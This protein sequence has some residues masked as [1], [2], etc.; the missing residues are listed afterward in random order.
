MKNMEEKDEFREAYLNLMQERINKVMET[1]HIIHGYMIYRCDH[2]GCVYFMNLEKGLEDP[3]DDKLTG[4][5][6]PVPFIISCIACGSDCKHILWGATSMTYGENYRSYNE[7]IN[8]QDKIIFRNLFW[9]DPESD[10]GV[11]VVF[12]PDF[13]QSCLVEKDT[14]KTEVNHHIVIL[15]QTVV[16]PELVNIESFVQV[17]SF[18]EQMKDIASMN[19]PEPFDEENMNREQRRHGIY[20]K[21]GY[22]RPRKNKKLYEY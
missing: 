16:L 6:K 17:K 12:E 13:F 18:E 20:G 9:N 15:P 5:H 1:D 10:C 4:K 2:C 21:D 3:E 22:K 11:P 7:M 14:D 8:Q 19:I